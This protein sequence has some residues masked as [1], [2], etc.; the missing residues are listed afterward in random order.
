MRNLREPG[1]TLAELREMSER[2]LKDQ[3]GRNA[4]AHREDLERLVHELEVFQETFENVA[5]GIAH[6]S[7]DG[8]FVRV[9]KKL[10]DI[11]G[12]DKDELHAM[13]FQD[14]THPEDLDKDLV[15][16]E[17]LMRGEIDHYTLE[18]RFIKKDGGSIWILLTA[19][20]Q[21]EELGVG[22]IEDISQR[23]ESARALH[24]AHEEFRALVEASSEVLYRMSPDWLTMRQLHSRGFLTD[25]EEPNQG[26]LEE[27]I[28]SEEQGRVFEAINRAIRNQEPFELEHRVFREDGTVGW[29]FSRAVPLVEDGKITEWFGSAMDITRS[30]QAE[31][32]LRKAYAMLEHRVQERTVE[33]EAES[34]RHRYL[35]K[36]LVDV[37]EMDRRNLSMMLHDD[38]GQVIAGTKI[39]IEVLKNDLTG[40]DPQVPAKIDPILESLQG[41]MSSLRSRSRELRPHTLTTLGLATALRSIDTG[42]SKCRIRSHIPEEPEGINQDMKLTIFRIAQEAVINALKHADC[43]EIY[44]SLVRRDDTLTLLVEDNGRGFSYD[45]MISDV[46]GQGPLGLLIMRERAANAGGTF[47]V[48]SVPG[49]GT[50]VI[51]EFPMENTSD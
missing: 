30:K 15:L 16:M 24:K 31:E 42:D 40:F 9:N 17:Q 27:Y 8:H 34:E 28:P 33:L 29:T 10:C 14:I 26:W 2:L 23:K 25:T 45:E 43:I 20:M 7:K 37:L 44:L 49:K 47:R 6:I 5:V 39:Q 12:Y 46:K 22:I 38:V 48:D 36:R 32:E 19:S 41:I 11:V 51:A 4:E 13:T 35:A 3:E 18:K 21:S 1:K 50:T